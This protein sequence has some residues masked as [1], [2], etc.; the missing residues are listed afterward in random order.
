MA[1]EL[2]ALLLRSRLFLLLLLL[3]LTLLLWCCRC[4][5]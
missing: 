4:E 3:S 2:G 5:H 1:A